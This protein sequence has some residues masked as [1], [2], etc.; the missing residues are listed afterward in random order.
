M[1]AIEG[2]RGDF[3]CDVRFTKHSF[4]CVWPDRT[5]DRRTVANRCRAS[6]NSPSARRAEREPVLRACRR[7][8]TTTIWQSRHHGA[9]ALQTGDFASPAFAGF[10]LYRL[11]DTL[12]SL[13][14]RHYA[15][16]ISAPVKRSGSGSIDRAQRRAAESAGAGSRE[17]HV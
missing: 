5:R 17:Q 3:T 15:I 9:S 4:S 8:A 6:K 2:C 12:D 11:S 14:C 13:W 10:A 7:A 16:G 1:A